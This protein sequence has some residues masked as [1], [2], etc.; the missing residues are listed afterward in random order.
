MSLREIFDKFH[1][2]G[3]KHRYG[4]T[5]STDVF[6]DK[7]EGNP[8]GIT[9]S[10]DCYVSGTYVAAGGKSVD[11]KMRFTVYISYNEETQQ[12]AMNQLRTEVMEQFRREF[13]NFKVTDVFVP[14]HDLPK[15]EVKISEEDM[16]YYGSRAFKQI[17]NY[18]KVRY[19]LGT[20][21]DIYRENRKI[22]RDRY[23]Y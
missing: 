20:A 10:V 13:P 11:V 18:Q 6:I 3:G 7:R 1:F 14:L 19:E 16:L 12:E 22:I 2:S 9:T 5:P 15:P 21:G 4:E 8:V 23:G 17:T